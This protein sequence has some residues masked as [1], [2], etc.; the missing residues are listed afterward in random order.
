MGVELV[1]VGHDI[2]GYVGWADLN[3]P[4]WTADNMFLDPS[5]TIY[6][7]FG[8]KRV[9][10]LNIL[11]PAVVKAYKAA[12][13]EQG[14]ANRYGDGMQMGH[15]VVVAG[16]GTFTYQHIQRGFIDQ[17]DYARVLTAAKEAAARSAD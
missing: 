2:R 16:D 4:A 5:K 7:A 9:S 15:T 17:P 12:Q 6:K 8:C 11:R 13:R 1:G 10:L 14:K 3:P